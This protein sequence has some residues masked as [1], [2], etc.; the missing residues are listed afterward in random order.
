MSS[1]HFFQGK[2]AAKNGD[3]SAA[4]KHYREGALVGCAKC[5]YETGNLFV[6]GYAPG[7]KDEMRGYR[8]YVAAVNNT[9]GDR[10][11]RGYA[12]FN[13]G[14]KA[15]Y[16]LKDADKARE[17]YEKAL[18]L[19]YEQSDGEGGK[20]VRERIRGLGFTP[21]DRVAGD[22]PSKNIVRGGQRGLDLD[23][24]LAAGGHSIS[25]TITPKKG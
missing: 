2:R 3:Y 16:L 6:K 7:G 20:G 18:E 15:Q 9:G 1:N 8:C 11:Y 12:A 10:T 21:I 14:D 22:K 5:Q 24:I 4:Y 25:V 23:A 17:H 13:A 19:G